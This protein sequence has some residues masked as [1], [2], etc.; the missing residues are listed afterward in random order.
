VPKI[1]EKTRFLYVK[2]KD[3]YVY[4]YKIFIKFIYHPEFGYCFVGIFRK[5]KSMIFDDQE[6]PVKLR[7]TYSMICDSNGKIIEISRSCNNLF[8][9]TP[10]ILEKF[11]N[12]LTENFTLSLLNP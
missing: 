3:G 5:P 9:I 4:P 7:K 8:K 12:S 11:H 10:D 2:D 1:L 6:Q